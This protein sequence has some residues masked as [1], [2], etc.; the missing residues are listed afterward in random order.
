MFDLLRAYV[1]IVSSAVGL[2]S[3]MEY[4]REPDTLAQFGPHS[5]VLKC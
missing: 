1:A 4:R 2:F 5:G 3:Q